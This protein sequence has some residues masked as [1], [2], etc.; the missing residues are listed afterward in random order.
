M[1]NWNVIRIETIAF[2]LC[3][4]CR[5]QTSILQKSGS[6]LV[7]KRLPLTVQM[8]R[9]AE[10]SNGWSSSC[11]KKF[12]KEEETKKEEYVNEVSV[13]VVIMLVP[14]LNILEEDD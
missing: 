14:N 10:N 11:L 4:V 1:H 6:P 13:I 12:L 8:L 3:K 5:L 7:R 9:R 2:N